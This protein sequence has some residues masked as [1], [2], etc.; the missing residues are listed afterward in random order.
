ME[1]NHGGHPRPLPARRRG[2]TPIHI[3]CFA[4]PGP[5][6]P[7]LPCAFAFP[8]LGPEAQGPVFVLSL[9]CKLTVVCSDALGA[10]SLPA[11]Q[12]H[13][14]MPLCVCSAPADK[15]LCVL[16]K[17]LSFSISFVPPRQKVEDRR[18]FP[19]PS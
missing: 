14:R 16:L 9:L 19:R 2:N 13:V 7:P 4:Q 8:Q 6:R 18:M 17:N 5:D 1:V 3:T 12:P 15:L 11:M 10:G